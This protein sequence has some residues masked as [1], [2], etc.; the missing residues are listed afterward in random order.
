TGSGRGIGRATALRFAEEGARVV[1]N[2]VDAEVA[3]D[4][5]EEIKKNGGQ[6][7]SVAANLMEYAEAQK[8]VQAAID[9][10][11]KL[12]IVINNAGT[13]KDKTFHNMGADV[14]DFGIRVNLYTAFNVTNA[15]MPFMREVAKKEK[16]DQGAIAYNRKIVFTSSSAAL[17]GNA[18]QANYSAAKGALISMTKTL[19]RELGPFQINVNA[20]APGF[21]ETR[22]TAPKQEGEELGIPDSTRNM[23]LMLIAVGRYGRPEDIANA[24]LF[25]ASSESDFISG[26]T[27]PVTGGQLGA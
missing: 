5:A 6:A 11:G 17:T 3:Q 15:A 14:F 21:V 18:G 23:A 7:I 16:A 1:I 24:H 22:L 8:V 19:A 2:D 20:V 9:E 13:T 25:L 27:L 26:V 10:W 4:A 12:D